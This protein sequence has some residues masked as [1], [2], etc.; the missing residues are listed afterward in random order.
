[1]VVILRLQEDALRLSVMD[2]GASFDAS[3]V[4]PNHLGLRIMR[5]RAEAVGARWNI[6]SQSG[7]GTQVTVT[8]TQPPETQGLYI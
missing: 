5:E 8:W 6:Y 7:E 4:P 3:A 2:N 1:V